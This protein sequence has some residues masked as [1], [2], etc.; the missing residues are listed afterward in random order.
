MSAAINLEDPFFAGAPITW[1]LP[2]NEKPH[3]LGT[4]HWAQ[5]EYV[6][7]MQCGFSFAMHSEGV[8]V[9]WHYKLPTP[10]GWR[11]VTLTLPDMLMSENHPGNPFLPA[12]R[13]RK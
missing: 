10:T 1:S 8:S 2:I 11:C 3:G 6:T 12:P 13:G 5:R 9:L 4:V 7:C